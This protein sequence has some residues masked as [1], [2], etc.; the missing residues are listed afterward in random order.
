MSAL[1][2]WEGAFKSFY[3]V[4]IITNNLLHMQDQSSEFMSLLHVPQHKIHA[5]LS[6]ILI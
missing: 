3:S 6:P 4:S 1:W 5:I 2:L